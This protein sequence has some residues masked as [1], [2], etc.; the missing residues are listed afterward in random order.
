MSEQDDEQSY[1]LALSFEYVI[2]PKGSG[3]TAWQWD[4]PVPAWEQ[5]GGSVVSWEAR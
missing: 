3:A 1:G 2:A 4:G 5:Q